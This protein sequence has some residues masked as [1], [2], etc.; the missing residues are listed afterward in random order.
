MSCFTMTSLQS[1]LPT[2]RPFNSVA[3][4]PHTVPCFSGFSRPG[5]L[6][7]KSESY[8]PSLLSFAQN[9]CKWTAMRHGNKKAKLGRPADQRK[10]L[11]RALTTEL[12]RHGKIKT[13]KVKAKAMRKPVDKMITL[14]K[15]G[16]LHARRQ[17]LAYIYDKAIVTSLFAEVPQ[18]YSERPGG[19]TRITTDAQLRRGDAAEMATIELV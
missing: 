14:A 9:G 5:R 7:L 18:R 1:S 16:T 4:R 2:I 8:A 15:N 17:A 6:P 10:A 3:Q 19:Y 12:L 11:L 13:T